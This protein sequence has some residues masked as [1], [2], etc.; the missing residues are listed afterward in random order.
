[1]VSSACLAVARRA[2]GGRTMTFKKLSH[3]D[4]AQCDKFALLYKYLNLFQS[5]FSVDDKLCSSI[6]DS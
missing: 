4:R 1:M 2:K 5:S 3:F 6:Y